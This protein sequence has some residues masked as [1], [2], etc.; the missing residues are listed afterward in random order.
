DVLVML[1]VVSFTADKWAFCARILRMWPVWV[2]AILAF[3]MYMFVYWEVRYTSMQNV[4]LWGVMLIAASVDEPIWNGRLRV[5]FTA[6]ACLFTIL[7]L[8]KAGFGLRGDNR[9]GADNVRFA[10]ALRSAGITSGNKV[11]VVG[12]AARAFWAK[13]DGLKIIAE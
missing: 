2:P 3:L 13:S 1:L 4:A 11:A 9:I 6:I 7:L 5:G 12:D 10:D 8:A